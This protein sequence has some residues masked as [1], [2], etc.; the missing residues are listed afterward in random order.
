MRAPT[1]IVVPEAPD[2]GP[3]LFERGRLLRVEEAD[4]RLVRAFILSLRRWIAGQSAD[5]H[6]AL[7]RKEDLDGPDRALTQ[8]VKG[9]FANESVYR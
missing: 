2:P 7:G 3:D 4:Q 6:S 5:G 8:L 9:L 1:I